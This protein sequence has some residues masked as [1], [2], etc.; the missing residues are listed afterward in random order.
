MY[1]GLLL[2]HTRFGIASDEPEDSKSDSSSDDSD[3]S[4]S[5]GS[6]TT[7]SK[8][9][10]TSENEEGSDMED[11]TGDEGKPETWEVCCANDSRLTTAVLE[12]GLPARRLT[13]STGY[14]FSKTK[15]GRRGCREAKQAK[16]GRC[17]LS[18]P[19]T[20]WS[21]M[22]NANINK[23]GH[24]EK[25][26][27]MRKESITMMG[28][29]L[30]LALAVVENGGHFYYEW[31]TGCHGWQVDELQDFFAKVRRL[32]RPVRKCIVHGCF[33]GLRSATRRGDFFLKKSWT[34]W[35]T[36]EAFA[37][38]MNRS[39]CPGNH[40]HAIVQHEDTARTAFYPHRM[41]RHIAE[42][43]ASS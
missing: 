21:S 2:S 30:P 24:A 8:S 17:W 43:W 34:I 27:R 3:T 23:P 41:A 15:H 7:S 5:G 22:Q 42:I 40:T 12:R 28:N 37:G 39:R 36:D 9:S 29:C 4:S 19:C 33:Y 31:P 1:A 35:T 6:S 10:G 18:L 26:V 13:L 16:P 38:V 20:A 32:G 14:D 25:L 11:E